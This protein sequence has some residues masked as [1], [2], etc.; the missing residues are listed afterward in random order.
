MIHVLHYLMTL[1]CQRC[2]T[3]VSGANIHMLNKVTAVLYVNVHV[4]YGSVVSDTISQ[5]QPIYFR[6]GT[7]QASLTKLMMIFSHKLHE[8]SRRKLWLI[9]HILCV[10]YSNG[11]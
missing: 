1:I 4:I 8:L 6:F 10:F 11:I 5:L 9:C 7:I 3:T 2:V